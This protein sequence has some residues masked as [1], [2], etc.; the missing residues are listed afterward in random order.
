MKFVIIFYD[1]NGDIVAE[2]EVNEDS[3]ELAEQYASNLAE[4]FGD[5]ET[6]WE[7]I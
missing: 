1:G 7:I 3:M 4:D 5:L 6:R 2:E